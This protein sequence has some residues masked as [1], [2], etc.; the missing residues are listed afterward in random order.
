MKSST[1]IHFFP[2]S[3]SF[4]PTVLEA[5][6]LFWPLRTISC[7]HFD[8]EKQ[9]GLGAWKFNN[10]LPKEDNIQTPY[11]RAFTTHIRIVQ[12]CREQPFVM[13]TN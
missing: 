13:E 5:E 3:Q 7:L 2:I 6:V 10:Q 9:R 1:D 4:L 12:R 8:N 11:K